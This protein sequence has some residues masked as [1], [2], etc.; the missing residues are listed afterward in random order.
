MSILLYWQ[1]YQAGGDVEVEA[2]TEA[3]T[4]TTLQATITNDINVAANV[5]ALTLTTL[6]ATIGYEF[7]VGAAT[8]ALTLTT[9]AASIA[10]DVNVTANTEALQLTTYPSTV[11]VGV[12][13]LIAANVVELTLT[14][15]PATIG[16]E[17]VGDD[18]PSRGG[19]Y[20]PS[21][22]S[23]KKV[24]RQSVKGEIYD[25]VGDALKAI[26]NA[27]AR[28]NR[29]NKRK[30]TAKIKAVAVNPLVAGFVETSGLQPVTITAAQVSFDDINK[31]RAQLEAIL[32]QS[33]AFERIRQQEDDAIV[34][35]LMAA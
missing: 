25:S 17:A 2:S 14:S 7:N 12:S 3:L 4:L 5:E 16:V 24:I 10:N 29:K 15:Y 19:I 1:E 34:A 21:H 18:V 11:S 22:T 20:L 27:K 35:L 23:S 6:Q 32:A 33:M 8:E 9:N 31:I 30:A 26:E 13:N 28:P